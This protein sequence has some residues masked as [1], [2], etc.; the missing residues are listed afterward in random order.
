[1]VTDS[2]VRRPASAASSIRLTSVGHVILG[3]ALVTLTELEKFDGGRVAMGDP[4]VFVTDH[5]AMGEIG[6]GETQPVGCAPDI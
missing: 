2:S 4:P 1:M 6:Q 5:K 3:R